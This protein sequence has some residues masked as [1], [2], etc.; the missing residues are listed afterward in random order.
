MKIRIRFAKEGAMKF[1]GH[2][3]MMR[4]FQKAMR[5]AGVDIRYSEGFSPHPIMSFAAPLGV[6]ITSRGE[7]VDIEVLSTESSGKMLKRLNAVMTEGVE[8]LSYRRLP[9]D[10]AV[11]MSI[12][13]AADYTVR[14]REG[15]WPEDWETF[16]AGWKAFLSQDAIHAH[17]KTKKGDRELDIRPWIY[18]WELGEDEEGTFVRLQ[19][20]A[21]SAANLKPEILFEAYGESRGLTLPPFVLLIHRDQVYADGPEPGTFRALEDFGEDIVE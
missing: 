7:Y 13:S 12:V 1:I 9:D 19:V 5:R 10:A 18:R 8:V 17:K 14:F 21:G 16:S 11:A 15:C 4:F 6:G 3:D 20:A 2:L